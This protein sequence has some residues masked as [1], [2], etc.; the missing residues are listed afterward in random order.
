M[1]LCLVFKDP[2]FRWGSDR[3]GHG[4]EFKVALWGLREAHPNIPIFL[5]TNMKQQPRDIEKLIDHIYV[6]DLL[7]ENGVD[8]IIRETG[9]VKFG[10]AAKAQALITG[11]ERG[12]I[13][14]KV[15]HFDADI[16]VVATYPHFNL[17]NVFEPLQVYL[18]LVFFTT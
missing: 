9:D 6:I 11:W 14:D 16:A 2:K 10:F 4:N 12:L 3:I 7:A 13:P 8:D 18:V 15:I 5:F 17:L 1:I